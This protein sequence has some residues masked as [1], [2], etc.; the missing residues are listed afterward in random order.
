M[1][2][3]CLILIEQPSHS[4]SYIIMV[5]P[6][7]RLPR[8]LLG[9]F[10]WFI[11]RTIVFFPYI[12][13]SYWASLFGPT[14]PIVYFCRPYGTV[15]V[16]SQNSIVLYAVQ[17]ILPYD[18]AGFMS[19]HRSH[20]QYIGSVEN[21]LTSPCCIQ[22]GILA[23]PNNTRNSTQKTALPTMTVCRQFD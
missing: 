11:T 4:R 10:F 6:P 23:P 20:V 14:M 22:A 5:P 17:H 13:D 7:S 9:I 18:M 16:H 1:T 2:S 3:S 12:S 8:F 15:P 19:Y 21:M